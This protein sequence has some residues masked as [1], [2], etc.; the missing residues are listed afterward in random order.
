[1]YI[2]RPKPISWIT[3][4][5]GYFL[6]KLPRLLHPEYIIGSPDAREGKKIPFNLYFV[7]FH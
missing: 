2:Y 7:L 3:G 6:N 1:M 4:V 5:I